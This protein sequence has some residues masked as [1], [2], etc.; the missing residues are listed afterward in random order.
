LTRNAIE[1][2]ERIIDKNREDMALR[3]DHSCELVEERIDVM[4]SRLYSRFEAV[5]DSLAAAKQ[6]I[7]QITASLQTGSRSA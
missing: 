4:E 2:I 6:L 3:F 7:R 1:S 5:E